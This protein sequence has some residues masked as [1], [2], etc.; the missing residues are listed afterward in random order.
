MM[1]PHKN[2][3]PDLG[4]SAS[5]SYGI[6]YKARGLCKTLENQD[7]FDDDQPIT[8][9]VYGDIDNSHLHHNVSGLLLQ[10]VRR[11]ACCSVPD[12]GCSRDSRWGLCQLS[13]AVLQRQVGTMS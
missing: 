12:M 4:Y 5:E 8:Y 7:I 2:C 6:S 9:A 11:N 3:F 10:F 13:S 1:L